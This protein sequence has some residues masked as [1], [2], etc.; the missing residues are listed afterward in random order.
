MADGLWR[1]EIVNATGDLQEEI[2]SG[3]PETIGSGTK[4]K[5]SKKEEKKDKTFY[6]SFG[7]KFK[8]DMIMNSVVSPLNTATGGLISPVYQSAKSIIGGSAVGATLGTLGA[9]F[10]IMAIQQGLSALEKRMEDLRNKANE[11]GNTDN[12]L[13]RAGSVSKTTYYSANIFGI[14]RKTNRS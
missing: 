8:E 5:S 9:T 4:E 3:A 6:S 11:L 2:E 13:I 7:D 12:A 14:K 10:A 1:F